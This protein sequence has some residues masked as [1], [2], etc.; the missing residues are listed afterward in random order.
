M[1]LK[2]VSKIIAVAE[3][4]GTHVQ[5]LFVDVTKLDL[6]DPA[7]AEYHRIICRAMKTHE[8]V[9]IV[10][11]SKLYTNGNVEI[12]EA[13]AHPPCQISG[14]CSLCAIEGLTKKE[15]ARLRGYKGTD[16]AVELGPNNVCATH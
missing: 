14:A 5:L 7:C 8:T 2:P 15:Q 12:D 9:A 11:Q 10:P 3:S 6:S 16:V 1:A 4:I 13:L